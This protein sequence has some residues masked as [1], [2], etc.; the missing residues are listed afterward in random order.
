M[1]QQVK[2]TIGSTALSVVL[3]AIGGCTTYYQVTDPATK[4]A[5]YSTSIDSK[6]S[7]AVKFTDDKTNAEV[8]LQSSEVMKITKEQYE[9]A[10]GKKK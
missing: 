9:A 4:T 7:G 2:R 3:A 10:V 5:Y 8:T 6:G 1:S